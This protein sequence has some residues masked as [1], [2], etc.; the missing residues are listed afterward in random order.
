GG[1]DTARSKQTR[2][3]QACCACRKRK[4]KC[5]LIL[6]GAP[7]HNCRIDGVSC[8][9]T[10]CRRSRRYRLRKGRRDAG[11]PDLELADFRQDPSTPTLRTQNGALLSCFPVR[12]HTNLS[13]PTS[14]NVVGD[15]ATGVPCRPLSSDSVSPTAAA[16]TQALLDETPSHAEGINYGR[17]GGILHEIAQPSP[18]TFA[19][20][21]N[22]PLYILPP[23]RKVN[24]DD[25]QF[26]AHRGA[27]SIPEDELRDQLLRAFILYSHPFLPVICLDDLLQALEGDGQC[28]ISLMLFHAVMFAGSAFVDE[29]YVHRAGFDD[30]RSARAFFYQKIKESY[31]PSILLYDFDWEVDRITLIQTMLLHTYWYVAESDQKDP[32]HWA[33]VCI[34]LGITLGLSE[35]ITYLNED[36]KTRKLW[37]RLFWCCYLR[38]RILSTSA[39]RPQRYRDIDIH[40]PML[41]LDDFDLHAPTTAI[42]AVKDALS[43]MT[44]DCKVALAQICIA[45]IQ[46]ASINGRVVESLY[47][48]QVFGG[49][50]SGPKTLYSPKIAG[51]DSKG[52]DSLES[53]LE[54]WRTQL[55]QLYQMPQSGKP[56]TPTTALIY[57]HQS[58]LK[59]L[60]LLVTEAL[61]RPLSLSRGEATISRTLLQQK[62]R[63][64]VRKCAIGTAELV[65]GLRERDLFRF[66][67]PVANTCLGA[68]VAYFL[69]EMKT[70]DKS[71][72]N[73]AAPSEQHLQQC[74]RGLWS[75]REVWQIADSTCRIVGHM[76]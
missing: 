6:F 22:L 43:A 11:V 28:Q 42:P 68:A 48:L 72:T 58:Y 59:M 75:L 1:N 25:L 67:P 12:A 41:I 44:Y 27:L 8:E 5:D 69:V 16:S 46:L 15:T 55:H 21:A 32:W 49:S 7:C 53:E 60:H 17:Q 40:I 9:T 35:R 37:R 45:Q 4:I 62:S 56:D 71:C 51:F 31:R 34:S 39:R 29:F 26:L 36:F 52:V 14:G 18:S 76:I 66:L 38:D 3:S 50:T 23:R 20:V 70:A 61:H 13:Q 10:E 57:L 74:I 63:P 19:E 2:A 47:V 30:R 73:P 65:Q 64:I 24:D 33:G 54:R